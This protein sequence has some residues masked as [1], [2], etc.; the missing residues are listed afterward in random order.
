MSLK[1]AAQHLS[2]HGRGPDTTLVHMSK[3][4]VKSL[5]DL[6]MAAGGHLTINPHTGLPEAGFLKRARVWQQRVLALLWQL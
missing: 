6:A 4:E 5:N 1:H 3:S 2:A